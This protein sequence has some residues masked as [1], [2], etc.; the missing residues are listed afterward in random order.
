MKCKDRRV[1]APGDAARVARGADGGRAREKTVL[2]VSRITPRQVAA[3]MARGE[4]IAF[5]DA[6]GDEAWKQ[7]RW[8]VAGAVHASPPSLVRDAS[9]VT[10]AQVVVV[11][12]DDEREPDVPVVAEGLRALGFR[13]VR[14]LAGGFRAWAELRY[15]TEAAREAAA[16]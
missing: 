4:S 13:Q 5:V 9:Q 11:Y 12:G 16:A 14:L 10:R 15:A 1:S 7:A 8:K 2:M 6:R 3:R